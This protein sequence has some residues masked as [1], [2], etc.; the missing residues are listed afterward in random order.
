MKLVGY[1]RNEAELIDL[2]D[3]KATEVLL[4]HLRLSRL[5]T[6]NSAQLHQLA[7][8]ARAYGLRVVLEWDILM[9]QPDF[10]R[11]VGLLREID[12]S[13]FDAIR[14]QDPGALEYVLKSEWTIPIQLN[15][16]QGNHNLRAVKRWCTH[17]GPRLE[18]VILSVEL[19][20]TRL[21][22]YVQALPVPVEVLTLGPILL[23]YTPRHLLSYQKNDLNWVK[24]SEDQ[25]PHW[26][27]AQASCEESFHKGF[28]LRETIHGTLLF[29]AKDY[30]LI[31]R[32]PELREIGVQYA[33]IDCRLDE[34]SKPLLSAA[35]LFYDISSIT[36]ERCDTFKAEHPR[37]V[38]RCFFQANA[39]DVLFKKLKN[40]DTQRRDD[41]YLGKVVETRKSEYVVV[42][43]LAK[44]ACLKP[45]MHLKF[46]NPSGNVICHELHTL[47]GIDGKAHT[48]I[49]KGA[50]AIL[51]YIKMVTPETAVYVADPTLSPVN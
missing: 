41:G 3:A 35:E 7:K 48:Q 16:E 6:L 50:Y 36:D 30:C 17:A 22:E 9:R 12:L 45:G 27:E 49:D 18:R 20:K 14:V 32:L 13:L 46:I 25:S 4:G 5:G 47:K 23:L 15:L 28:R 26:L 2:K 21:S 34:N 10:D 40:W 43:V 8:Q 1:A 33:R 24:E 42:Q 37:A 38:T 39:T 51:P 44:H 31:D 11:C 29:H 19:P